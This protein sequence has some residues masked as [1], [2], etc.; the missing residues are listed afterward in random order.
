[1]GELAASVASGWGHDG[2]ASVFLLRQEL[3]RVVRFSGLACKLLSRPL[4]QAQLEYPSPPLLGTE[5]VVC[6]VMN[7]SAPAPPPGRPPTACRLQRSA[8]HPFLPPSTP[9]ILVRSSKFIAI[10]IAIAIV[11]VAAVVVV[12]VASEMARKPKKVGPESARRESVATAP[13]QGRSSSVR[14][15]R[16]HKVRRFRPGTRALREIR[17]FQKTTGFLIRKLPF[18]R[19]VREVASYLQPE[20]ELRWRDTAM[21]ALQ[22]AA[23]DYLVAL[24][25]DANLCAV[26]A[27]RVTCMVKDIQLARRIRGLSEAFY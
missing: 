14:E 21:E 25:E 1:M 13:K 18:A 2:G 3:F 15:E 22:E 19:L 11:V 9:F 20:Y 7:A 17:H 8:V 23:E 4:H 6:L 5:T 27:K 10:A 12:I 24:L 16:G 26:H